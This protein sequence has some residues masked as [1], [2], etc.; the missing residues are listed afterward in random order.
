MRFGKFEISEFVLYALFF[1]VV[2]LG[3]IGYS[4]KLD[5]EKEKTKQLEI[6]YNIERIEKE[7]NNYESN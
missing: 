5:I 3:L 2:I 7:N 4:S 6:K 1:I